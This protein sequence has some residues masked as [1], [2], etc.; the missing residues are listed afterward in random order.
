[1]RDSHGEVYVARQ[2]DRARRGNRSGKNGLFQGNERIEMRVA[3]FGRN[4]RR[5]K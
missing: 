3:Y 2:G 5:R 1:M 4:N